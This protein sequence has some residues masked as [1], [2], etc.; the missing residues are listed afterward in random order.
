M[1]KQFSLSCM[2]DCP[3]DPFEA[4][5][6]IAKLKVPWYAM[7]QTLKSDGVKFEHRQEMIE[8]RA[9]AAPGTR[10]PRIK[11]SPPSGPSLLDEE[12]VA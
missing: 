12:A 9:K 8:T 10:K 7:L 3:P 6:L 5:E 11:P 1:P 2:V 4:A